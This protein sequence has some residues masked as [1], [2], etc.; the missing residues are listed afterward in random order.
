LGTPKDVEEDVK[1]KMAI[2]GED[3]G[4]VFAPEH[5]IM[6]DVPPENVIAMMEAAYKY[7]KY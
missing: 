3:G 4:L 2:L 6:A 5:N 1:K 7:G